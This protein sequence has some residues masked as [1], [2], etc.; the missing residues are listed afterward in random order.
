MSIRDPRTPL[1]AG[2]GSQ[3]GLPCPHVQFTRALTKAIGFLYHNQIFDL[4]LKKVII[5]PKM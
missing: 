2:P 3:V 4:T 1:G 5:I